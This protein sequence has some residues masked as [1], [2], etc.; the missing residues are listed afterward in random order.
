MMN[1]IHNLYI[2]HSP[3]QILSAIEAKE[4]FS[5]KNNVLVI[6][7]NKFKKNNDLMNNILKYGTWDQI[8][9]LN[10]DKNSK[11][12]NNLKLI[13][14]L[15]KH[16]YKYI[17]T[18]NIGNTNEAIISNL[19][20][21]DIYLIDDGTSTLTYH[22]TKDHTK[23]K[24]KF[25][26]RK[27]R[28]NLFFLKCAPVENVKYFTLFNIDSNKNEIIVKNKFNYLRNNFLNRVKKS[29]NKVFIIGQSIAK[30][31]ITEDL[32]IKYIKQ[33]IQDNK[34]EEIVYYPHRYEDTE[35]LSS[36]IKNKN[37]IVK[38][39][40]LPIEL[41][42]LEQEYYPKKIISFFSAALFTLNKLFDKTEVNSYV[43]EYDKVLIN[44]DTVKTCYDE[45]KSE[46]V[47]LIYL[48]TK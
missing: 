19:K 23:V 31:Y 7:R 11:F 26:I 15:K 13:N 28:Y 40:D 8:L 3:L 32:Y 37:F 27:M 24:S 41:E 4:N 38:K 25:S 12:R 18:G 34:D 9:E 17:F 5:L 47:N 29:T 14:R 21:E 6:V 22:K 10:Y 30:G 46:N 2:V 20:N 44:L 36:T 1:Q 35:K 43:I 48:N 42:L 33:I 45:L 39:V 16:E